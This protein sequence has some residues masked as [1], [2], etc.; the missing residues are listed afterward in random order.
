MREIR[1]I[2]RLW[3]QDT[4]T[5]FVTLVRTEGS[6]YRRP[7]AHLLLGQQ[8]EYAGTIS[9]GCLEAEV[10]RKAAWLVRGGAVMERYSTMFDD[11]AEIPFGLGCGGVVDLLL[12]PA[13]TPECHAVLK[14]LEGAL[15]GD[16]VTVLT[17]LP[18][19]GR[20]LKRAVLAAN[21]DFAYASAGL[22][23][24]ELVEA[25]AAAVLPRGEFESVGTEV[26]VE[27]I[28]TPQRLFI[29]GAGDDAKPV[30]S[31]AA[32]LGWSV[33]VM[34]GRAHMAR[35]E[36]FPEAEQVIVASAVSREVLAIRPDDAV[37][38]MS[39]SYEQ[40]REL[41]AAVLPL[42]PKYLGLLGARRRSSLLVS[43]AAATLGWTVG[44]CCDRIFAPV[45]LDLG[46]DGPEAIALAVIAEV[47]ACCMGK[48][49][50]SRRLSS[51]DV[52]RHLAEGDAG[53][54]LQAQCALD[55]A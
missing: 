39:H 21:G 15:A 12:E 28:A 16:E 27:R 42:R 26:F 19:E 24:A 9:G 3:H 6:S 17:W 50:A 29:L 1:Q 11:T 46:G 30:V 2:V 45:G 54:Y 14:A 43:E 31:M 53:R 7:G 32:L 5:V 37:V 52:E 44:E 8:G 35:A 38:L 18:R 55:R 51:E 40:D 41:L 10:V 22:T 13:D 4:A 33:S 34:D 36:R 25:R 47:Q 23:E 48:L 49:G 20:G